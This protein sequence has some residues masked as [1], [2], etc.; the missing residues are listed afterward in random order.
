MGAFTVPDGWV[1]QAYKFALDPTPAQLRSFRSHAGAARFAYNHMLALIKANIDQ[2]AAER[3][4]GIARENLTP[5]INWTLPT[6]RKEWNVRKQFV[7]PWWAD[8]SKEAYNTGLDGLARGLD[9]WSKSKSGD[10]AARAVKFPRFK[11]IRSTRSVRFTTGKIVVE[12]D[13]KHVTLPRV[14]CIKTH[15]STR[16]LLRRVEQGT[17]RVLAATLN[18]R[19][20]RWHVVFHVLVQRTT[21][22]RVNRSVVG[23]DLGV[24]DLMV[25][26]DATGNEL[27]RLPA[28]R[29]YRTAQERTKLLQRRAARKVGPYDPLTG[30]RQQPSNRWK[31][32]QRRIARV[33]RH[34]AAV[35]R[36]ALHKATTA[37]AQSYGSIAIETLSVQ[38]MTSRGGRRKAG[39]NTSIADASL[40]EFRQM[41]TYKCSWYGA[42]L[43]EANRWYP[44]SKTCSQC[45]AVKAKLPLSERMFRCERCEAQI[46]RDLNAAV[47]LARLAGSGP[48]TGRGAIRDSDP[49]MRV[50]SEA[51][52][53][54]PCTAQAG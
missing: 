8:N 20:G 13:R 36:D 11:T 47:N 7:A 15:E 39:L 23:V 30:A 38:S 34:A 33:S 16:K 26:A 32:D 43:V 31:R 50:T 22:Q 49:A 48:V 46:D 28:P 12:A 54:Q 51:T 14:G 21:P 4:Y 6:L 41:L 10:I 42:Q 24:K 2:R 40:A 17:A 45:G 18:E 52:K 1:V 9:A 35:R 5:S 3:T 37:L 29:S 19:T 44:S 53:R 25:V 27:H